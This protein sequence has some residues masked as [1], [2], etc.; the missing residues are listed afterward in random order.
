MQKRFSTAKWI[1]YMKIVD[2]SGTDG[3]FWYFK[4]NGNFVSLTSILLFDEIIKNDFDSCVRSLFTK[5]RP[6]VLILHYNCFAQELL[7]LEVRFFIY[8][9]NEKKLALHLD[10]KSAS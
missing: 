4:F 7:M 10:G 1:F 6:I 5:V 9:Q 8:L 3:L 2:H